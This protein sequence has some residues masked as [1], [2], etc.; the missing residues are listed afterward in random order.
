MA[1]FNGILNFGRRF[2]QLLLILFCFGEALLTKQLLAINP[3]DVN[4]KITQNFDNSQVCSADVAQLIND[5][6]T[7]DKFKRS[8]WGI[9]VQTLESGDMLYALEKDKYFLPASNVKLLTTA[10]TLFKFGS[11]FRFK[12]PIYISGNFPHL[13]TLRLVGK[14]DPSLTTEKLQNLA[15]FLKVRGVTQINNLIIE[16]ENI[17]E[18]GINSTWEWEDVHYNYATAVNDLILNENAVTLTLIPQEIGEPLKLEWSDPIAAEQW[19]VNHQAITGK[20]GTPYSIAIETKL[21]QPILNIKG[22]LAVNSEPDQ[23]G[24]AVVNPNTYFLETLKTTLIREGIGVNLATIN[25]SKKDSNAD[26]KIT[27]L[28]SEKLDKLVKKINQDS[29][30]LYAESLFNLLANNRVN[31][32]KL[33]GLKETLTQLGV[34]PT[35]YQLKDGSG[36]SRQNLV[37]P[38]AL[39][40]TLRLMAKTPEAQTYRQSLAIGGVNG[41]LKNRFQATPIQG[42]VQAKTGTLMGTSTLSGY[43]QPLNYPELVFSIMVNQSEVSL[44]ELRQGIDDIIILLSQLKKC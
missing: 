12:T 4:S 38:E 41:T 8:R 27:E 21:G 44:P 17:D 28:E 33:Q 2:P 14:G 18:S 43:L 6:I 39:V 11:E 7:Q 10:A 5:I 40:T 15:K 30:N 16:A 23:F 22:E 25:Q 9:L 32:S 29:H 20:K 37:T 1:D 24:L 35:S 13:K 19:Q 42:I 34:N 36:L 26:Q 31:Q 3:T